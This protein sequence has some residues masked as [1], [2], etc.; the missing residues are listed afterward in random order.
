MQ[1]SHWGCSSSFRAQECAKL[2]AGY[3]RAVRHKLRMRVLRVNETCIYNLS[4]TVLSI[5]SSTPESDPPHNDR[6]SRTP[7]TD[8]HAPG[9]VFAQMRLA[10]SAAG[11]SPHGAASALGPRLG[12]LDA[13][14]LPGQ[15]IHPSPTLSCWF[16]R[17]L[18]VSTPLHIPLSYLYF[19]HNLVLNTAVYKILLNKLLLGVQSFCWPSLHALPSLSDPLE[20][21]ACPVGPGI[22]VIVAVYGKDP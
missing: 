7:G 9:D 15:E 13:H 12:R 11:L 2:G 8:S 18:F 14:H 6:F 22:A 10:S 21:T 16:L 5:P 1:T 4:V 3:F 20:G 19:S 17:F